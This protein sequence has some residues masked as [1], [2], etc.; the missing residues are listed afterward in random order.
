MVW[1]ERFELD[2]QGLVVKHHGFGVLA[3]GFEHICLVVVYTGNAAVVWS[4]PLNVYGKYGLID[5][6]GEIQLRE[7]VLGQEVQLVQPAVILRLE[8]VHHNVLEHRCGRHAV[9]GWG[10]VGTN[11]GGHV[12]QPLGYRVHRSLEEHTE[13]VVRVV[14]LVLCRILGDGAEV[15]LDFAGVDQPFVCKDHLEE[16]VA[17]AV[18]GGVLEPVL[19]LDGDRD[20]LVLDEEGDDRLDAVDGPAREGASHNVKDPPDCG[21]IVWTFAVAVIVLR[22]LER[23]VLGLQSCWRHLHRDVCAC[24]LRNPLER[25]L[26][27][28]ED[29][30]CHRVDLVD[31]RD[32]RLAVELPLVELDL[33]LHVVAVALVEADCV[34]LDGLQHAR[35]H[36]RGTEGFDP[37]LVLVEAVQLAE[38]LDDIGLDLV[39]DRFQLRIGSLLECPQLA[40]NRG[41]P[42]WC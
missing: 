21:P 29:L 19:E 6:E 20:P 35:G 39:E 18:R 28:R 27:Q 26:E 10:K 8:H 34:H 7:G 4:V 37:H 12:A 41:F 24:G 1:S 15:D 40:A 22:L 38:E 5:V 13:V 33:D 42:P 36:E 2:V 17:K 14:R 30:R 16:H 11:D 3:H 31:V 25:L 23:T 32:G 9:L